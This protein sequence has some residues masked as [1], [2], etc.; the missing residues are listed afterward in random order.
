MVVRC[1]QKAAAE[2]DVC[3][4]MDLEDEILDELENLEQSKVIE[5]KD[6]AIE[7]E[8]EYAEQERQRAEQLLAKLKALGG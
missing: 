8:R 6:K 1:L 7:D 5:D 4:T 2:T 3:E